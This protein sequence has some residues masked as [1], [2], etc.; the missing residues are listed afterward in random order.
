MTGNF[1]F[2]FLNLE[3]QIRIACSS[4]YTFL[5]CSEYAKRKAINSIPKYT[6][7][8]RV[9]ID[10]S[11]KKARKLA[12]IFNRNGVK[13]TF[14]VRLHAPEY[15]PFD[16]ENYLSLKYIRDTGHE[17]GYHS[18]IIDQGTIWKED[19]K[20]CLK[21]DIEVLNSMLEIK[22]QGVASHGGMT[23]LNNLD[24]WENN[25]A[26]DFGLKYEAY[27]S[28]STFN[29]FEDAFYISD[30]DWTHWKCYKNGNLIEGDMRSLG[31]HLKEKHELIYLLIHPDT[32]FENHFYE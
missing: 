9:D 5:T 13:G 19:S 23:G 27:E 25:K 30:S 28:S 22:V 3:K 2:T 1:H 16:F 7:I 12:E 24:F 11:C 29:L 31:E 6:L 4:G 14:F 15:N 26:V 20:K 10:L 32:F 21:R 17:I 8:V 18:E